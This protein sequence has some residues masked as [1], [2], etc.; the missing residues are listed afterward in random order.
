VPTDSFREFI[1]R[2]HPR[3]KWY[4]H[5][6]RF[7]AMLQRVADDELHR[8]IIMLPP[9]HSKSETVSRLFTAYYLYRHSRSVGRTRLLRC[10]ARLQALPRLPGLRSARVA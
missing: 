6:E 3:F 2:V 7:V 4:D 5:C 9:R 10:R 1:D 8:V